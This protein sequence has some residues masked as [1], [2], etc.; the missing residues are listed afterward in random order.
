MAA[1]HRGRRQ[2]RGGRRRGGF[3][4]QAD[5]SE[6][7]RYAAERYIT[8]VPEIDMPAH[9]QA[10]IVSYPQLGC[11]RAIPDTSMNA[12]VAGQYTGIRVGFSALCHDEPVTYQFVEDVVRELAALTPGRYL[13][14]GGDEVAVLTRAQY[15]TFV[16]RV[17][18]IV[19]KHGKT[20]IGW[21]EIGHAKLDLARSPRCGAPTPRMAAARQG[22]QLIISPATKA[23]LDMKYTPATELGL[24]GPPSSTCGRRTAGTR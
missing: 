21:D 24:D 5:Y 2:Q 14:L 11:G 17:Q 20:M 18:E 9:T 4:T 15:A 7:V 10:A 16:E 1:T 3:Y 19:A 22:A 23:Y 6:I 8:V 13:H 12:Q